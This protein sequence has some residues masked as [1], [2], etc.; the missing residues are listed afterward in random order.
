MSFQALFKNYKIA[1][2][3]KNSVLPKAAII[4]CFHRK[5]LWVADDA[6]GGF[7]AP[8]GPAAGVQGVKVETSFS[9][10]YTLIARC[11]IRA[12]VTVVLVVT[13]PGMP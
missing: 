13:M 5:E 2:G 11:I 3:A 7:A 4:K 9:F 1:I 6:F 8:V 10:Q 12:S